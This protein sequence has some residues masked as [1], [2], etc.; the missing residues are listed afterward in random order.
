MFSVLI[1]YASMICYLGDKY[2]VFGSVNILARQ[3]SLHSWEMFALLFVIGTKTQ[4]SGSD[5]VQ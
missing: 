4:K 3:K 2:Q 1:A 5:K